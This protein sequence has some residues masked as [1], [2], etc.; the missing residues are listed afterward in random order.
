MY[1]YNNYPGLFSFLVTE[2]FFVERKQG[3]GGGGVIVGGLEGVVMI[4]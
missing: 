2:V 4:L 3:G 1:I